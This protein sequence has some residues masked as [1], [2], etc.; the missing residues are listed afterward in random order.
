MGRHAEA[1][2]SSQPAPLVVSNSRLSLTLPAPPHGYFTLNSTIYPE[3]LIK[4]SSST[5][6]E[7]SVKLR[8][9]TIASIMGKERWQQG[10]LMN[11]SM[12]GPA[13]TITT[14]EHLPFL[15]IDIPLSSR[16]ARD[17]KEKSG[18]SNSENT[19]SGIYEVTIPD[20][21][22]LLPSYK[23]SDTDQAGVGVV[24]TI[25]VLGKRS[26]LLKTNDKLSL[27]LPVCFSLSPP[28]PS[29]L[30]QE[31][32]PSSTGTQSLKFKSAEG[33]LLSVEAKLSFRPLPYRHHPLTYT[34][35]LTPS[36]PSAIPLLTAEDGTPSFKFT[37][38]LSR[39][40]VT[41][42]VKDPSTGQAGFRWAGVRIAPGEASEPG[43]LKGGCWVLNG[44]IQVPGNECTIDSKGV[45]VAFAVN[46]HVTSPAFVN[47][48]HVSVPIFLPSAPQQLSG[49]VTNAGA[50]GEAE[51]RADDS[52][53]PSY[54]A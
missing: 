21:G 46:C 5:Y 49:D 29:D 33:N 4:A 12:G 42:P 22:Q 13:V 24:Y 34:V 16:R 31:H 27:E 1:S 53:L 25:Q 43:K 52:V 40:V 48:L 7:L 37:T 41:T 35:I 3:L 15:D 2:T 32:Y 23:K 45:G 11:A 14:Q 8:G 51:G 17:T 39:K 20:V 18:G 6:T 36:S 38:T 54:S 19:G 47:V 50:V 30:P 44:E 10:M 26:G 28:V 9:E